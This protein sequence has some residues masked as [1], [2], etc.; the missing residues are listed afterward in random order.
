MIRK[1]DATESEAVLAFLHAEINSTRYLD[2]ILL[3]LDNILADEGLILKPDLHSKIENAARD[4]V[5]GIFRGY[6]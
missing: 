3:S 2:E 4:E 5:L 1:R 6:G